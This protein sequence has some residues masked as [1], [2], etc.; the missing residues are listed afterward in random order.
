NKGRK[1]KK[2][3]K[4]RID[5]KKRPAKKTTFLSRQLHSIFISAV[6]HRLVGPLLTSWDGP[7]SIKEAVTTHGGVLLTLTMTRNTRSPN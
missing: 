1:R 4:N 7:P 6:T 2:I 5:P 3:F